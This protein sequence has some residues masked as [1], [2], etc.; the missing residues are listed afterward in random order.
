M[1]RSFFNVIKIIVFILGFLGALY[2]F[3]PWDAAGRLALSI[4]HRQLEQRGMR[5][6]FSDVT[7]AEEGFTVHN[8]AASGMVNMAFNSITI[9]PQLLTSVLSLAPVCDI[10]FT[11]LGIQLGQRMNFGNGG[12][13]LTA[14]RSQ[15]MLE[16]L[17]TNGDFSLNG[18][19][20]VNLE[21]MK[22]GTS[23]ARFNVP[24]SFAQNMDMI[25]N[26]LPLVQEGGQ[27]Y[28]RRQ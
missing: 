4:A 25:K 14:G 1:K 28:L 27:W 11:G 10:E 6:N 7:A 5:L 21:T 23:D 18:Y 22:I 26:F 17:R 8:L 20:S 19:M 15:I 2:I 13:L 16:N 12:F 24:E 3:M 9:R